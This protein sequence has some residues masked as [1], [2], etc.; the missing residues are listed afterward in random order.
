M[1]ITKKDLTEISKQTDLTESQIAD[2]IMRLAQLGNTKEEIE[3]M[4][5]VM[6]ARKRE[7]QNKPSS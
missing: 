2:D 1:N 4:V 3:K 5:D 7:C 6:K